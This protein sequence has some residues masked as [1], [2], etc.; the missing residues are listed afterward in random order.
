MVQDEGT[1]KVKKKKK[2]REEHTGKIIKKK[3]RIAQWELTGCPVRLH[4]CRRSG[5]MALWDGEKK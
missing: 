5:E 3:R 2:T 4:E 1:C